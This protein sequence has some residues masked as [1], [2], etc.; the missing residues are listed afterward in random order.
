MRADDEGAVGLGQVTTH[1]PDLPVA[2]RTWLQRCG[3][4]RYMQS[5]EL[6]GV[7]VLA[8]ML[9]FILGF[10][11]LHPMLAFDELRVS[12]SRSD[13]RGRRCDRSHRCS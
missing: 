3:A 10:V 4:A 8:T 12:G 6:L 5:E 13:E 9:T 7:R 1:V 11:N 2:E